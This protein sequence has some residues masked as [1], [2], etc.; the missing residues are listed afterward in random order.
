MVVSDVDDV[1]GKATAENIKQKGGNAIY[2]HC[3]ITKEEECINLVQETVKA[4]GTIDILVNNAAIFVLKSVSQ[5]SKE[6]KKQ[7]KKKQTKQS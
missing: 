5:A 1:G 4:F 3:D 7:R 2:I 6:G